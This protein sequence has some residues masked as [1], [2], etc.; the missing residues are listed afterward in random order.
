MNMVPVKTWLVPQNVTGKQNSEAVLNFIFSHFVF[1]N[2]DNLSILSLPWNQT[3]LC[4]QI[5]SFCSNSYHS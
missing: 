3:D 1:Y 5:A 4:M 2:I